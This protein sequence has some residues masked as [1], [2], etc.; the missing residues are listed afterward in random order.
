MIYQYIHT[1]DKYY[2]FSWWVKFILF[3]LNFQY[4][5]PYL[6]SHGYGLSQSWDDCQSYIYT[7]LTLLL[8]LKLY[9]HWSIYI[10]RAWVWILRP[11]MLYIF[12]RCIY[13]T[14]IYTHHPT[15]TH[16]LYIQYYTSIV[17]IINTTRSCMNWMVWDP[18]VHLEIFYYL[19]F[20]WNSLRLN[21][22][23]LEFFKL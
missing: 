10:G 1:R 16:T 13:Y 2:P 4:E 6:I 12:I 20:T 8:Q 19:N 21:V 9:C 22:N 5:L 23:I 3:D 18:C 11:L 15:Y 14:S 17:P 7:I